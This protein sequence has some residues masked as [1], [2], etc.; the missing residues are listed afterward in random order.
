MEVGSRLG[1]LYVTALIGEGGMGQ[2]YQATD[3][4]LNRQV[5]LKILPDAFASDPDRLA[6]FQRE[7]HVLASLNH[8][9]I[10]QI[11]GLEE[12]EPAPGSGGATT[13]ALVLELVEGPTLADRISK[14]PIPIDE[15]L[16]IA[17]Q[18]ADA[19]EAAHDSGVIHRD[20]KPANIK[21]REDGTVK[22]LDFGLAKALGAGGAAR[23]PSDPP[24]HT[25]MAT[26]TGVIM[27]T[28][29]YMSPEQMKG[30][31]VDR[32]TDVWAFGCVLY[33][34]LTGQRAFPADGVS[35]TLA[36]VLTTDVD[37]DLLPPETP[38]RLRRVLV[39]CLQ[40][41]PTERVRD[42]GDVR[43]A[44]AGAFETTVGPASG[45]VD[46][47]ARQLWQRPVPLA[48]AMLG[49]AVLTGLA[50]WSATRPTDPPA[51]AVRRF[52]IDIGP[53][54]P[55][56]IANVH[57]MPAWSPDGTRLVYAAN[58]EETQQ[59]PPVLSRLYLRT[60]DDLD[61]RPL[62]GTE[63]AY[64]PFFSPDGEWVGFCTPTSMTTGDLK[65]VAVGGGTPLTVGECSPPYGATWLPDGTIILARTPP[66]GVLYHTTLHR[67]PETGGTPE[68]LT[69]LDAENGESAHSWPHALPGGTHVLFTIATSQSMDTS[70]VAVLS[71]ETFEQHV[72]VEGGYH[73][74]YVPTGHLIFVREGALWGVPFDLDRLATTG[75]EEVVLQGVEVQNGYGSMALSVSGDGTLVYWPGDAVGSSLEGLGGRPVWVDRTGQVTPIG[76]DR[77]DVLHPRLSPD[78]T[79]LA[80]AVMYAQAEGDRSRGQC[81][82]DVWVDDLERG[83]STRLTTDGN[84]VLPAWSLEGERVYFGSLAPPF[85][86]HSRA[87]DGSG[88][89]ET[90]LTGERPMFP[91]SWTRDG[92]VLT[93]LEGGPGGPDIW[94]I[95]TVSLEGE[96]S[97]Y[98]VRPFAD[99]NHDLSPDGRWMAYESYESGD[100][101]VYI[102]QYPELGEKVTVSTDGGVEPLWSP[103]GGEL[104]YRTVEGDRMMVVTVTTEPTLRVSRPEV[105]FEGRY[106]QDPNGALNYDVSADGKR[107]LML[108]EPEV[109]ASPPAT[110]IVVENWHEELKRLVPVD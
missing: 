17:T 36:A 2:V 27:G 44:M 28:A 30:K 18:I 9:N 15:A 75:P 105:L 79:R 94:N 52:A 3:T 57:A 78:N 20:L 50:V 89:K 32:R 47:P 37:L 42:I 24:T 101:E 70:R 88:E 82:G 97:P 103:A 69:T 77:R 86:L 25:T 8:P 85:G 13:R 66:D 51:E 63:N 45:G 54:S 73:A 35:E 64:E 80:K 43:L 16:P 99:G 53:A 12:A 22:V 71:L 10:A 23:D 98:L 65:R 6:R 41:D 4:T 61:A 14:G 49:L 7:A 106:M 26:A 46:G 62:E 109:A 91:Y 21:V 92:Q 56:R 110:L 102:Q 67:I 76:E 38:P 72:V 1:H 40:K 59:S 84:G 90:L 95:W 5:A 74:R 104:F 60:L 34:M 68:P 100:T 93:F 81:C 87:A 19:L 55:M 108:S 33:E 11:H 58:L 31:P 48:I 39:T 29:A 96:R 83:T 107:F